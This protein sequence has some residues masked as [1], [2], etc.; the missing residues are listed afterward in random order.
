MA[1][2]TFDVPVKASPMPSF[3]AS[4]HQ[5]CHRKLCLRR[6]PKSEILMPGSARSLSVLAHILALARA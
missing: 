2:S 1:K 5:R 6:V 3:S 4:T